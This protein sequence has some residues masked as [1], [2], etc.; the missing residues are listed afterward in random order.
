MCA[1]LGAG[2]VT[3]ASCLW[4]SRSYAWPPSSF[5]RP[6]KHVPCS[7]QVHPRQEGRLHYERFPLCRGLPASLRLRAMLRTGCPCDRCMPWRLERTPSPAWSSLRVPPNA[8]EKHAHRRVLARAGASSAC[9]LWRSELRSRRA[10]W[11]GSRQWVDDL[12]EA[13]DVRVP[14]G[15][16]GLPNFR[17]VHGRVPPCVQKKGEFV[18]ESTTL[19]WRLLLPSLQELCKSPGRIYCVVVPKLDCDEA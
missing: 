14:R 13:A 5:R 1:V 11:K 17:H 15:N 12:G 18:C 10:S 9:R 16:G 8:A 3:T 6:W 19:A 7:G 2:S 4:L